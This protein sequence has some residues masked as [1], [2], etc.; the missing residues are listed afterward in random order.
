MGAA[1]AHERSRL[2]E[3]WSPYFRE[4]SLDFVYDV[5][6]ADDRSAYLGY[7]VKYYNRLTEHVLFLQADAGEHTPHLNM[8]MD[9]AL[10]AVGGFIPD[11]KLSHLSLNHVKIGEGGAKLKQSCFEQEKNLAGSTPPRRAGPPA[12]VPRRVVE[13]SS[14]PESDSPSSEGPLSS[15]FCPRRRE[16]GLK[17]AADIVLPEDYEWPRLWR[18]IFG[19]SVAPSPVNGEVNAY[20]CVQFIVRKDRIRNRPKSFYEHALQMWR[21]EE[22]YFDLF[23]ART[24]VRAVD[25][26]GRTPCQLGMY[27]WHA[28]FGA[29][30]SLERRQYD[31]EIPFFLKATNLEREIYDESLPP[32]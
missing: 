10:A 17:S 31:P 13:G 1:E 21:T 27:F 9:L 20:C 4:V 32:P 3:R 8:L 11:L 29:E 14:E 7:L 5:L 18:R 6:R 2:V 23:P 28:L 22:S 15:R 24:Y 26:R 16:N 12:D 19:S 30:L 25:V